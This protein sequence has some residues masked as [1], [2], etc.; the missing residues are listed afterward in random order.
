MSKI[1]KKILNNIPP[2]P[3]P[4]ARYRWTILIPMRLINKSHIDY[5]DSQYILGVDWRSRAILL[6]T[7]AGD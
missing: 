2:K 5:D 4:V 7:D 1:L 6:L 3:C